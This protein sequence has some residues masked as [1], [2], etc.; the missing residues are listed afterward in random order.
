V[1]TPDALIPNAHEFVVR[2]GAPDTIAGWKA[3]GDVS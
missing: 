2:H 3:L 1:I